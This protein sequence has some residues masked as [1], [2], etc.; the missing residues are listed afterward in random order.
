MLNAKSRLHQF[1]QQRH[2]S[3]DFKYFSEGPDHARYFYYAS[4]LANQMKS[5]VFM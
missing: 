1:L 3:A 5:D 4:Y 2:I